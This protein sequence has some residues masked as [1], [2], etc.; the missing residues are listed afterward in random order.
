MTHRDV[1]CGNC[2]ASVADDTQSA[3]KSPCPACGSK[4]RNAH[5]LVTDLG[6]LY[7]SLRCK[8]KDL[9]RRSKDKLR[10]DIFTGYEYSHQHKKILKKE[11][12]I[13]KDNDRYYEKVTDPKTQEIIHECEEKLS[14][15]RDRGYAKLK[16]I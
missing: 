1:T 5:V 14:E 7:D 3:V 4:S 6:K 11:R 9:S 10:V 2:G 12:K 15:H 8:Q 16:K 13:D